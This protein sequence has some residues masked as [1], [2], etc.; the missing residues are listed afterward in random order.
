MVKHPTNTSAHDRP[1]LESEDVSERHLIRAAYSFPP[2]I[3]AKL[4]SL[5]HQLIFNPFEIAPTICKFFQKWVSASM[6]NLK[7]R[8]QCGPEWTK[9]VNTKAMLQITVTKPCSRVG[10]FYFS[11]CWRCH[12]DVALCGIKLYYLISLF[13]RWEVTFG[14]TSS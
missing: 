4:S 2:A 3:P 12:R 7:C 9:K 11:L 10:W 13:K 5:Q 14:M 6:F 1:H 8:S